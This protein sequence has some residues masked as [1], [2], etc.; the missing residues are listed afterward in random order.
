[1]GAPMH[2][3]HCLKEIDAG[4]PPRHLAIVAR[5]G[6]VGCLRGASLVKE[7]SRASDL[8]DVCEPWMWPS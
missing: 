4:S 1:M 6:R 3:Q 8:R 5:Y 2:P 7:P